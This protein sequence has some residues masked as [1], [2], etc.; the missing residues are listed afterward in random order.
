MS[1]LRKSLSSRF[2]RYCR[3]SLSQLLLYCVLHA[4]VPNPL[5][6]S[7]QSMEVPHCCQA[8]GDSAVCLVKAGHHQ[9]GTKSAGMKGLS[10]TARFWHGR[11]V[12]STQVEG[13]RLQME[14]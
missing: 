3:Q 12:Q 1:W 8:F 10:L 2:G 11:G 13:E 14:F 4:E 7:I 9:V 5:T 6:L